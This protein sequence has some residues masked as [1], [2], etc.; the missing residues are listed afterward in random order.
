V[1]DLASS[2]LLLLRSGVDAAPAD[3][4]PV[5]VVTEIEGDTVVMDGNHPLAGKALKFFLKVTGVRA[6]TAEEIAHRHVHGAGGHHH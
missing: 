2:V 3:D 4:A 5:M 6:A 1:D